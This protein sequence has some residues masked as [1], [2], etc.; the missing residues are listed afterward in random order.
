MEDGDGLLVLESGRDMK[1]QRIADVIS[2][3]AE[4]RVEDCRRH[5]D[6]PSLH[7]NSI[8]T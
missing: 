7:D 2:I 1:L 6:S 5:A 8:N 4:T 3:S